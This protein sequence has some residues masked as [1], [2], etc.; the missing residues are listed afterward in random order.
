MLAL[1]LTADLSGVTDLRPDDTED[2]PF[3]Y[4]FKVQCTSC[5]ETHPNWVSVSR[6]EMNEQS[7]SKGEANFVWRCKNC[8]REHSANIKEAPKSYPLSSPPKIQNIIEFDCRGLEFVEFKA[9][10]DWLAT[11]LE[12]NTKFTA[13]DLSEGDWYDYDEKA[14]D[15]VSIKDLKWQVR[16]A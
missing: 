11:G 1:A 15:E 14:N 10:G 2:N 3:F 5:R 9:D 4:T 8:K 16:R 6:F 12:S 7:G 13:I